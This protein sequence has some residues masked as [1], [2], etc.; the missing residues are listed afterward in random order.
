[1]DKNEAY[2]FY[3]ELQKEIVNPYLKQEGF[4]ILRSR[5]GNNDINHNPA[6]GGINSLTSKTREES[7]WEPL[8]LPNGIDADIFRK[9]I[10]PFKGKY[11][12]IDFWGT[13]CGPCRWGIEAKKKTRELFKKNGDFEFIF[14]TCKSWS[15]DRNLY[16]KYVEKQCMENSFF[17]SNDNFSYLM[18]LFRFTS[19]PHYLFIDPDGNVLDTDFEMYFGFDKAREW[20]NEKKQGLKQTNR[21]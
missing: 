20:I 17:V 10:N 16:D 3:Y 21:Q 12:F 8:S 11:L 7:K 5:F 13:S 2:A 1:M 14:I 15:P 4:R 6:D 9:L 18:Q 19:V